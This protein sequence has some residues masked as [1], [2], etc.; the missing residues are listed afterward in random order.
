MWYRESEEGFLQVD[1][2]QMEHIISTLVDHLQIQEAYSIFILNP[3]PIGKNV[4]YGY[5]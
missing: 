2:S 5:R 1:S 4:K 3:K